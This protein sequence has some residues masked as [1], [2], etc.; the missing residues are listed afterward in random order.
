MLSLQL[1]PFPVL[2]TDRLMLKEITAADVNDL[3]VLRS[4]KNVM[5]Y[6]D[7]PIAQSAAD[8]MELIQKIIDGIKN[9]ENITWGIALKE[10]AVLIGTIGFWK[11]DLS[12]YRAEIGYLLHPQQQQ[13]GIMQ[14][15]IKAVLGCG[16][17]TMGLH[18]VEANINPANEASKNLLL[19]NNFVQE[20][21]FK[22]NYFYNG[23]FLDSVIFSLLA[24][25]T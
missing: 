16:F 3:L 21:H 9:N 14:E 20:A 23:R 7:R 24:P 18:S 12:N 8:A 11:I 22:E 2:Y 15:A 1:N 6:I 5:A 10:D 17:T 19:K 13:K 25:S 4:D